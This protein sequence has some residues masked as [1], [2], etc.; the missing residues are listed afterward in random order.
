[1]NIIIL[2]FNRV[3]FL[4]KTAGSEAETC[5]KMVI[6]LHFMALQL[7]MKVLLEKK[8]AEQNNPAPPTFTP[9]ALSLWMEFDSLCETLWDRSYPSHSH[10]LMDLK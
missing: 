9:L 6:F 5:F 1:M 2:D 8:T 4:R 7:T 3:Q 10:H